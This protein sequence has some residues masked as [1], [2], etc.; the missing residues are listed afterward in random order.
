MSQRWSSIVNH[1]RQHL[2]VNAGDSAARQAI[3]AVGD[4][5]A[6]IETM[7]HGNRLFGWTSM[8][9]LCIQQTDT[10]PYSGP[11]LRVSP[12]QSAKVEFRYLDTA[13]VARQWCREVS[14]EEVMPR[15]NRFLEQL[16]WI[17]ATSG[18]A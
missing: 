8:F 4:L 13:I 10:L 11:Y 18:A 15:F 1:Y 17:G 16:R 12:L 3:Q 14:P 7:P 6:H 2:M 9:D 5:A